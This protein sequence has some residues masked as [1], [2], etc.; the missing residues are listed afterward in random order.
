M[1]KYSCVVRGLLQT[2]IRG[3][4]LFCACW[5][6]LSLGATEDMQC[7]SLQNAYGPFDYRTASADKKILV[8]APHYNDQSIAVMQG[9]VIARGNQVMDDLH[10]TLRVFPNH[11]GALM[12]IDRLGKIMKTEKPFHRAYKIECYY[13]RGVRMAKDDPMVYYLY[14][15][16][17][18]HR[19]RKVEARE[20]VE[21][22]VG[23]FQKGQSEVTPNMLYN[24]GLAYFEFGEYD[25][26]ASYARR[27]AEGGFT[28]PGLKNKLKGVGHWQE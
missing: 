11:P 15:M 16:Y 13:I 17:L 7:G 28:L 8:E 18:Q 2:C 19:G 14:G 24:L 3:I 22:A 25:E 20:K 21:E 4:F 26:A 10:Y 27:A 5:G 12:A 1:R 9:K 6:Q 23:L